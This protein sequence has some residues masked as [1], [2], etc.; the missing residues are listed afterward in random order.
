MSRYIKFI[1][2]Y[3]FEN[4]ITKLFTLNDNYCYDEI[5]L[6]DNNEYDDMIL[7]HDIE[8]NNYEDIII[9]NLSGYCE[10]IFI[11]DTLDYIK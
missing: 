5:I 6:D 4:M 10:D 1:K 3:D 11:D 7:D 8:Y 9:S 2:N